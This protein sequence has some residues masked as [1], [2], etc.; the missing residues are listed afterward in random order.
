MRRRRFLAFTAACAALSAGQARAQ[1]L[2]GAYASIDMRGTDELLGRLRQ[3]YGSDKRVAMR[4]V[5]GRPAIVMPPVFYAL[6]SALAEERPED[7]VYWYQCGRIRAVYDAL[8]CRDKTARNALNIVRRLLS[9]ELQKEM[10]YRRDR[11]V[12]LAEKAVAWD[13][14]T[15]RSYDQRWPALYGDAA[16][17]SDGSEDLQVPESEWPEVLKHVHEAHLQ[18]VRAFVNSKP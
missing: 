4:E 7:A 1:A 10:F 13:L 16:K 14:D 11:L 15:P 17:T 12:R 3:A 8:R 18:S 2:R 6:G 5:A 9:P